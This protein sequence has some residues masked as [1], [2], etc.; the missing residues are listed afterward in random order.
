MRTSNKL[1]NGSNRC[2]NRCDFCQNKELVFES[3]AQFGQHLRDRHST[4]EGGSYICRYGVNNICSSL[5]YEGVSDRDYERHVVKCHIFP[6]KSKPKSNNKYENETQINCINSNKSDNNM[7][8]NQIERQV[9]KS[10]FPMP[11]NNETNSYLLDNM[12]E[13]KPNLISDGITKEWNV[14]S[15][16]QNLASVLNDPSKPRSYSETIFTKDWGI[17]FIDSQTIS[18]SP[19]Y[20]KISHSHFDSYIKK[21][22]KRAK[23]QRMRNRSE[24]I[25]LQTQSQSR[26]VEN[27]VPKIFFSTEFSL[28]NVETFKT[29]LSFCNNKEILQTS[30]SSPTRWNPMAKEAMK[31]L[32]RNFSEYLDIVEENLAKQISLRSKNFFQ[33][34]STMDTVMEQLKKTIK[35]VT[36]L[37]KKCGQ[38]ESCLIRPSLKNIQLTKARNNAKEVFKKI[39][40]IATV[41]QTQPTIQLL[42]S[43]LDFVGA[44]DL[45]STSQEVVAQELSGVHSFR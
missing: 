34:M 13:T 32:Q 45:I 33:V 38:L 9:K 4:R 30:A 8:S 27:F 39:N 19:F 43:T 35:E 36:V 18:H 10:P 26:S 21:V 6:N 14:Y 22:L 31:E 17:Y 20:P 28:E 1:T 2:W 3:A 42:L 40:L 5:P 23:K 24:S 41:H 12:S 7:H 11:S 37:R 16:S 15:S 25:L 29:V 44:L